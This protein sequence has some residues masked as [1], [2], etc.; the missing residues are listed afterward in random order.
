MGIAYRY[1]ELT[2]IK[3]PGDSDDS[4]G[5]S[6]WLPLKRCPG[7]AADL[8]AE[9]S[10]VIVCSIDGCHTE[11]RSR[12]RED[13]VLVDTA[14]GGIAKGFHNATYCAA[15]R[16][17]HCG[18][19]DEISLLSYEHLVSPEA[20]DPPNDIDQRLTAMNVSELRECLEQIAL[21]PDDVVQILK[22]WSL[23]A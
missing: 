11:T 2:D 15:C 6:A 14:D 20:D 4:P 16:G 1:G 7:C 9:E 19:C 5:I 18:E 22:E 3:A 17:Q 21:R 8:T 23:D 10:I 13:G 12:L